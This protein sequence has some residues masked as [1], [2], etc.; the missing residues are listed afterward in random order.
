[1]FEITNP[2]YIDAIWLSVAF[3]CGL[4]AKRI[5]L[6]PLV[7]F[8][9]G[10]FIINFSG[11]NLGNLNSAITPMADIGVMIL[12]FT[13]GL[14]LKLKSLFKPEI[15]ATASLHIIITIITFSGLL[16]LISYTGISLFSNLS[17]QSTLIISFAL[18]F[19][20][21]VFVVKTLESQG[22][23][24]SFHGKIA[25]GIL[26]IQDIFAV[27]FIAFSDKKVP[28]LWVL[29]LPLLL[30]LIKLILSK[31]LNILEH[32]E[33]VPVFGFFATFIAGALSFN[34][35][36][37][38]PDLGALV[39]GMLMV[40]HPRA[41]ELYNRMVEYKDFFLIA[42][43][44]NIGLI[45]LPSIE[46]LTT[47]LILLPLIIFKGVL[48]LLILS[49]FKIRPRTAY[50]SSLS[51]SNF[52]E[53]G[54]IVGVVGFQTGYI[55]SEWI[56]ALALLM[57]FSF[58]IS[59]PINAYSH[60]IFD[61]FKSAILKINNSDFCIDDEPKNIGNAEYLVIGMGSLGKPAY[62]TLNKKFK[63][64]VLGFDYNHDK[65][66]YLK[67]KSYNVNW[68]D[69]TDSELWDNLDTS[70][71][72][73]V[74]LTMGD[75][76]SNI[77]TMER[78]ERLKH[79]KFKTYAICHYPDQIEKFKSFNVD[80][81]FDYKENLGKDFVENVMEENKSVFKIREKPLADMM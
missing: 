74:F 78:I 12:L 60:K 67:S 57:S 41:D 44:I 20:S 54:L 59:A 22:E 79:K 36:G 50:L 31:I 77:N 61:R 1:M 39:I 56:V 26:I 2:F 80:Y 3:L 76:A 73:A 55:S 72:K 71:I 75:F 48:F 11:F 81:V 16:F 5:G 18:S 70:K 17:W 49:R 8:L 32:G 58:V 28:S 29:V 37:L 21:T 15:W 45:G 13:I 53:F 64:K 19:S 33:M 40:N 65:I 6:P 30:Y 14:K 68:A 62:D 4:I 52:S 69:T 23:F 38:K 66:E 47:S 25:I 63:G 27:G 34:L 24:D 51:L 10:G 9:V 35:F 46:T 43:F 7:G 42:F